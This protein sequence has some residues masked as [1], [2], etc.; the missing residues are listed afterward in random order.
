MSHSTINLD[1][2]T[3]DVYVEVSPKRRDVNVEFEGHKVGGVIVMHDVKQAFAFTYGAE[4]AITTHTFPY[5]D[6]THM[7]DSSLAIWVAGRQED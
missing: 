1:G 2:N 4:D 3:Y 6:A 7:A 5:K